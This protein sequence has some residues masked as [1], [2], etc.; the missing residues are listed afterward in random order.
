MEEFNVQEKA[1]TKKGLVKFGKGRHEKDDRKH[2]IS[3]ENYN[4]GWDNKEK[5]DWWKNEL[6]LYQ[7]KQKENSIQL[8][9]INKFL[10][11]CHEL[12]DK[13]SAIFTLYTKFYDID[14][15]TFAKELKLDQVQT[16]KFSQS[17]DKIRLHQ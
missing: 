17:N 4:L 7:S 2:I 13:Y 12:Q 6:K 1:I 15:L 9:E 10:E 3:K 5:L 14:W 8:Y 11:G 16:R